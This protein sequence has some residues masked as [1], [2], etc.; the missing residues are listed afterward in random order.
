MKWLPLWVK[1]LFY[2]F[3]SERWHTWAMMALSCLPWFYINLVGTWS[4]IVWV[5]LHFNFAVYKTLQDASVI[6][7]IICA[8]SDSK[9]IWSRMSAGKWHSDPSNVKSPYKYFFSATGSNNSEECV[10]FDRAHP[11]L[12]N[13]KVLLCL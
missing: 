2:S 4:Y 12:H 1:W 6:L 5:F 3:F 11:F 8:Y 13:L 10:T 9:E 7:A